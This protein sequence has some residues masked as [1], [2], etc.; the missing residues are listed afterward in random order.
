[1]GLERIITPS[2][3]DIAFGEADPPYSALFLYEAL[4]KL[5]SS[6]A[7]LPISIR[8]RAVVRAN[9]RFA[10]GTANPWLASDSVRPTCIDFRA[11]GLR[12]NAGGVSR[13]ARCAVS[14]RRRI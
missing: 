14:P 5:N 12:Q 13:F 4:H 1:M 3:M 6:H 9:V 11:D 10:D 7:V 8:G 2:R